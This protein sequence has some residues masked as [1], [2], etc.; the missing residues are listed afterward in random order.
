MT[1]F[2]WF[3]YHS[4]KNETRQHKSYTVDFKFLS[5]TKWILKVNINIFHLLLITITADSRLCSYN[6]QWKHELTNW[7]CF[8]FLLVTEIALTTRYFTFTADILLAKAWGL[9]FLA[10]RFSKASFPVN[11]YPGCTEGHRSTSRIF[12]T[13]AALRLLV[14]HAV[15]HWNVALALGTRQRSLG[16][17]WLGKKIAAMLVP[18]KLQQ[19]NHKV[20][21]PMSIVFYKIGQLFSSRS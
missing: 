9:E 3:E 7:I 6:I 12:F 10:E 8:D 13:A 16:S 4:N 20:I 19:C 21:F 11:F 1:F 18:F 15:I 2:T 5:K 17:H 14:F